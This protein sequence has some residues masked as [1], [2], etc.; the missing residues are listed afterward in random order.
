MNRLL[1]VYHSLTGGT[2]QMARAAGAGAAL[3]PE[4]TVQFETAAKGRVPVNVRRG[5]QQGYLMLIFE[6]QAKS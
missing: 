3:E 5:N 1:I 4:I 2:R 6:P